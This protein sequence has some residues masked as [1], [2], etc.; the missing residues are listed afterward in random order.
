MCWQSEFSIF[1]FSIV[2]FLGI[3]DLRS[4]RLELLVQNTSNQFL[5]I[6]EKTEIQTEILLKST[7]GNIV[8]GCRRRCR[9]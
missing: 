5:K 7:T 9:C 2:D 3:S 4:W 8:V 6:K 1:N